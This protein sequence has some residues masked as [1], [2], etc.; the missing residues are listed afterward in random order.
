M[1]VCQTRLAFLGSSRTY[2]AM[3]IMVS[4]DEKDCL[5]FI[6][7][8]TLR[9]RQAMLL[10]IVSGESHSA[11]RDTDGVPKNVGICIVY[12][13]SGV[14]SPVPPFSRDIPLKPSFD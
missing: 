2:Q 11:L 1:W 14:R 6:P 13:P 9:C 5:L 12:L 8:K 4:V 3:K 10:H 7:R